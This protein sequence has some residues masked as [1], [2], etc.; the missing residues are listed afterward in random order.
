MYGVC[1]RYVLFSMVV[2]Y[3]FDTSELVMTGIVFDTPS[4]TGV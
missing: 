3:G 4:P 2:N 1:K